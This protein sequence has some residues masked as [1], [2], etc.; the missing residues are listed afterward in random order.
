M[1]VFGRQRHVFGIAAVAAVAHVVDVGKAVIVAIVDREIDHDALAD[2]GRVDAVSDCHDV[3][4]GIGAL[5]AREGQRV[6][7]T[8]PGGDRLRVVL[9]AV[10][11]LADPDVGVVHA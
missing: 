4:D 11:A 2:A 10:G 3:A 6:A 7:L 8:A 9:G 1:G 5:D